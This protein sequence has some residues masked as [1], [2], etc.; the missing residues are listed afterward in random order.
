MLQTEKKSYNIRGRVNTFLNVTIADYA[1]LSDKP[2]ISDD[3]SVTISG[4]GM[5]PLQ[6][7]IYYL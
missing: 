5:A 4:F 6:H 1:L 3:L 7:F 2:L